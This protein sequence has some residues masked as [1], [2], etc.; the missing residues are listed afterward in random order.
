MTAVTDLNT[1]LVHLLTLGSNVKLQS[2]GLFCE[3]PRFITDNDGMCLE[4]T[5]YFML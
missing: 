5:L 4:H 3:I 2:F 1:D